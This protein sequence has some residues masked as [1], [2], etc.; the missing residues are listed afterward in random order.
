MGILG[1]SWTGGHGT[2]SAKAQDTEHVEAGRRRFPPT[3]FSPSDEL[4]EKNPRP[5]CP[6]FGGYRAV[7]FSGPWRVPIRAGC[8]GRLLPLKR[9]FTPP[10]HK[11][12]LRHKRMG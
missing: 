11:Q 5:G 10:N 12:N 2:T 1:V 8:P 3:A 9:P 7:F 6:L 4:L